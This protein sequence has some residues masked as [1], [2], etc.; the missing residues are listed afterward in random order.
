MKGELTGRDR[1]GKG[2][3]MAAIKRIPAMGQFAFL[4][5]GVVS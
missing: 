3:T 2:H 4:S 1:R 5:T